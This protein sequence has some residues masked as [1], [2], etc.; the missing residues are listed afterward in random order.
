MNSTVTI[1]TD[2]DVII[3][4]T[5]EAIQQRIPCIIFIGCLIFIGII[6]NIHVLA[7]FSRTDLKPS[8]YT[9][10]VKTLSLVDLI[11]CLVHMPIEIVDLVKPYTFYSEVGC[12]LF[13]LNNAF[14]VM[15]S[16][17][18]LVLIAIERY[19][20]VCNLLKRQ[21]T[22]S[23]SKWLCCLVVFISLLITFPMY[24]LNG[25]HIVSLERNGINA[26]GYMCF[27]SDKFH[28]STFLYSYL[29]FMII[30]F[31]VSSCLLINA[32][33]SIS[34]VVFS[35][36]TSIMRGR[37]QTID[38]RKD[39]STIF[40]SDLN[41]QDYH[42][43]SKCLH[44]NLYRNYTQTGLKSTT[45][46]T[47]RPLIFITGIFIIMFAPYLILNVVNSLDKEF[48]SNLSNL[49]LT[50]YQIGVRLL[51]INNVS[52]PFVYGFTDERFK[53]GMK[54]VYCRWK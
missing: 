49:E 26:T 40:G 48:K 20:R 22:V 32:Y 10:F 47:T 2:E 5:N 3:Q 44:K 30:V 8:T 54:R 41:S 21:M 39:I 6:G 16:T 46:K 19:R 28:G 14:L 50:F 13:R 42:K 52:N 31:I 29:G 12:K 43:Y 35:R 34:R 4:L 7:L 37:K 33:F 17:S 51:L 27:I 1:Y 25:H 15:V 18:I 45:L 24:F 53:N 11:M 23:V 36:H 9:V 38:A